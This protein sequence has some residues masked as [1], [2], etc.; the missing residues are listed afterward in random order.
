[1][2]LPQHGHDH[3]LA[4]PSWGCRH[5]VS[6]IGN[7]HLQS[8]TSLGRC[9]TARF[10][11]YYPALSSLFQPSAGALRAAAHAI[12]RRTAVHYCKLALSSASAIGISLQSAS[13]APPVHH[14]AP[15]EPLSILLIYPFQPST[16]VPCAA[17]HAI[18]RRTAVRSSVLHYPSFHPPPSLPSFHSSLLP[19]FHPDTQVNIIMVIPEPL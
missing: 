8:A 15:S 9:T 10:L 1:M 18:R 11:S 16:G 6:T 4:S 2:L 12:C 5:P 7:R 19:S 14:R 13:T 3:Q 17:A